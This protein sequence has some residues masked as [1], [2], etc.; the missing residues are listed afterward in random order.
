MAVKL[1]NGEFVDLINMSMTIGQQGDAPE[2]FTPG[3]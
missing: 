3:D 1:Y 2:R